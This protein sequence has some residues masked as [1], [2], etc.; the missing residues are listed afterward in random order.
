MKCKRKVS[1]MLISLLLT[2]SLI[3]SGLNIIPAFA[4]EKTTVTYQMITDLSELSTD[5]QYVLVAWRYF[6][7]TEPDS[8]RGYVI[9][10]VN[11]G[12][13]RVDTADG[14]QSITYADQMI[15]D[16]A[17]WKISGLDTSFSFRNVANQKYLNTTAETDS[18]S[19]ITYTLAQGSVN[20]YVNFSIANEGN[21][22]RF[23]GS[24][25]TF[26][27]SGGA[28]EKEV[29][30]TN[31]CNI[32]IYKVTYPENPIEPEV[33][34]HQIFFASDYQ[35]DPAESNL[36]AISRRIKEAG[37]TPERAVWCGD[38]VDGMVYEDGADVAQSDTIPHLNTI[39]SIMSSQ[40]PELQYMFLQGNHDYSG[41]ITDGTFNKTGAYEFEDYIVYIINEDD[42]PWWQGVDSNYSNASANK[43]TVQKTAD[44]LK[45]FFD[46]KIEEGCKKPVLIA[47][48]IPLNWSARSTTGTTWWMDN[49]YSNIL[50]PVI[51]E[52]AG[53]LD[54]VYLFGHN[55]SDGYDNEI[56]GS[57]NYLGV[58]DMMKVP[59][60]TN[61]TRNYTNELINFTYLNAGYIGKVSTNLQ[62]SISTASIITINDKEIKIDKYS[63]SGIY[64][65]ATKVITRFHYGVPELAITSKDGKED[66]RKE[67]TTEIFKVLSANAEILS[68]SW[69]ADSDV[70]EFVN[71]N[72]AS[73]AEV[74]YIAGG[75]ATIKCNVKYK[76]QEGKE[77]QTELSYEVTVKATPPEATIY[78]AVTDISK[79][80]DSKKYVL[81]AWRY[82]GGSN[83]DS[84]K[85]YILHSENNGSVRAITEDNYATIK[86]VESEGELPQDAYWTITK[87]DNGYYLK[88]DFTGNYLGNDTFSSQEPV[89]YEITPGTCG[90]YNNFALS[91]GG[92]SLRY[93]ASGGQFSN[94]GSD[95]ATEVTRANAC[96]FT[97]Y[98]VPEEEIVDPEPPVFENPFVDVS[99][100]DWF[101]LAVKQLYTD[102]IMR[103]LDENKFG[104][105]ENVARAQFALILYRMNQEPEVEY[106]KRFPDVLD[107][108]W[109]TNAVLWAA[110]TGVVKGYDA[111]GMFGPAD[112]ITRE[113][114]AVMLYRYANYQ[115]Y[116]SDGPADIEKYSDAASVNNFAKE[117]MKWAV[118][119]SII[120]GKYNETIL[121]PQGTASR[122]ECAVMLQRFMNKFVK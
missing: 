65:P 111:T 40:W 89:A 86:S 108:Q 109:F 60:G 57:V 36:Q 31:A 49:I 11:N 94:S 99:E 73:E 50:F 48:H 8:T 119:N 25:N 45:A 61:G 106:T 78:K 15:P 107:G 16:E 7:G 100:N 105:Y 37:V 22:L 10:N 53:K 3:F 67:G 56:G 112:P 82:F 51:N 62:P 122:A 47:T 34:E 75:E 43:E 98:Q 52:A 83:S 35:G 21:S 96:N 66:E 74:K 20:G 77:Q 44:K 80:D 90:G 12:D 110:D 81:A 54:V 79:L 63:T 39:K 91:T 97:I 17:L 64:T 26:S 70:V 27:F 120:T 18:S 84:T 19:E 113:Q 117:A 2:L 28:P 23:S 71:G 115:N 41:Y 59:D 58:G 42:F 5:S 102:N 30:G 118:G 69:S 88:N 116:E 14:Y 85:G 103:G 33:K 76:D 55:H 46:E 72:Q 121:D 4:E 6:G 1:A 29:N 9:R 104:P 93:S 24:K 92:N 68:Y 101:Y 32:T 87:D 38:Y 13:M 114:M 95:G